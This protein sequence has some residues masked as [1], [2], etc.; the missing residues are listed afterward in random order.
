MSRRPLALVTS[1]LVLAVVGCTPTTVLPPAGAPSEEAPLFASDEEALAA[2]TEAYEEFLAALDAV[3]AD[4][5][6]SQS[7]LERL[8]SGDALLEAQDSIESFRERRWRLLGSRQVLNSTLQQ[9]NHLSGIAE[10]SIYVCETTEGTDVIDEGGESQVADEREELTS[11]EL[12]LRFEE[13]ETGVLH[14]R[15]L[16]PSEEICLA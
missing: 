5:S 1:L 15:S 16:W 6:G 2:A 14:T 10:V 4:P 11:F 3:L 13:P 7:T 9:V 12:I 8:A